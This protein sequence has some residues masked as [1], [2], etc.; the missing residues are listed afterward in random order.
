MGAI[1]T[2]LSIQK[3]HEEFVGQGLRRDVK[4][5]PIGTPANTVDIILV[6]AA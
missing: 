6:F 4:W 3:I 1:A 2:W 5:P